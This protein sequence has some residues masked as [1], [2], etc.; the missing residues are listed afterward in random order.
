M[1][2]REALRGPLLIPSTRPHGDLTL[3]LLLGRMPVNLRA[4]RPGVHVLKGAPGSG[5]SLVLSHLEKVGLTGGELVAVDDVDG[6]QAAVRERAERALSEVEC[7]PAMVAIFSATEVGR[8]SYCGDVVRRHGASVIEIPPLDLDDVG[9]ILADRIG[10]DV[11]DHTIGRLHQLSMGRPALLHHLVAAN[12][13]SGSLARWHGLWRLRS[14]IAIGGADLYLDGPE[15]DAL[16][17]PE[18]QAAC[19]LASVGTLDLDTLSVLATRDAVDALITRRLIVPTTDAGTGVVRVAFRQPLLGPVLEGRL[20]E[21]LIAYRRSQVAEALSSGK[22]RPRPGPAVDDVEG[23]G[24]AGT[25]YADLVAAA[26]RGDFAAANGLVDRATTESTGDEALLVGYYHSY[27][28]LLSGNANVAERIAKSHHDA[29]AAPH[30]SAVTALALGMAALATGELASAR[31]HLISSIVE[32]SETPDS[33]AFRSAVV[34]VAYLARLTSHHSLAEECRRELGSHPGLLGPLEG[35]VTAWLEPD[36]SPTERSVSLYLSAI[37]S[38]DRS[39]MSALADYIR[40]DLLSTGVDPD[41]LPIPARSEISPLSHVVDAAV[42]AYRSRDV[43][44]LSRVCRGLDEGRLVLAA[45]ILTAVAW[46]LALSVGA[47]RA[48]SDLR[49]RL[50]TLLDGTPE[51][52]MPVLAISTDPLGLTGREREI[53]GMVGDG[54]TNVEIAERL[55][56]SV[57]TVEGHVLRACRRVGAHDRKALAR[58]ARDATGL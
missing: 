52:Q 17:L 50:D 15:I 58:L 44:T 33:P 39:G 31:R 57:R 21:H 45:T 51:L 11:E 56:L 28:Y 3:R 9:H 23:S 47:R 20:G 19:L 34:G 10:A 26:Y 36:T 42:S 27:S 32:L 41:V 40:I 38:L 35:L 25:A 6:H 54:L 16:P 18:Q 53:A 30:D 1:G 29:S 12:L 13:E 55:T 5:K 37:D 14:P 46:R 4:L 8:G 22:S 48:A 2:T 49:R 7:D 24:P 43:A